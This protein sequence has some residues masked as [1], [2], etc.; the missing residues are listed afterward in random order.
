MGNLESS[1]CSTGNHKDKVVELQE[2]FDQKGQ[3]SN[4]ENAFAKKKTIVHG[5]DLVGMKYYI[6]YNNYGPEAGKPVN[7]YSQH[8]DALRRTYN[9]RMGRAKY[10]LREVTRQHFE[11]YLKFLT[12][13]NGAILRE[14]ERN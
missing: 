7:P 6:N 4:E 13:K 2:C 14:L 3:I 1:I 10:E 9:S 11:L 12:T 8:T 5:N